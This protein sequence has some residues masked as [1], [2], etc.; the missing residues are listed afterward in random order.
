M[1]ERS[2]FG[3]MVVALPLGLLAAIYLSEYAS[4]RLRRVLKPI[5]EVRNGKVEQGGK[6]RTRSRALGEEDR[7]VVSCRHFLGLSEEETAATLGLSRLTRLTLLL[8]EA[9]TAILSALLLATAGLWARS[10]GP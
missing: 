2:V 4:P 6:Q 10:H 5:V 1:G 9:R 3:A 7:L 8:R